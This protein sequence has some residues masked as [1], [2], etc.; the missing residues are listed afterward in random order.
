MTFVCTLPGEYRGT[1]VQPM[2]D[3]VYSVAREQSDSQTAK[4]KEQ[5][6]TVQ[7]QQKLIKIVQPQSHHYQHHHHH[8]QQQQQQQ[9]RQQQRQHSA[10][11]VPTVPAAGGVQSTN[12]IVSEAN[13]E[14][15]H[16]RGEYTDGTS[17]TRNRR[18]RRRLRK[19]LPQDKLD[20]L[21]R[22]D[23]ARKRRKREIEREKASLK[24]LRIASLLN[25]E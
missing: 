20:A 25:P 10:T 22:K 23:A 14:R 13:K 8:Q 17:G 24:F 18:R 9:Q 1:I 7:Q 19:D 11:A 4:P 3:E 21:R 16:A 15:R 2:R 6:S 5:P 12:H